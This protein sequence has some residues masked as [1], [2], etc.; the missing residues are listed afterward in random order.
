MDISVMK[1]RKK[2][3]KMTLDELS[4]K[5]GIPKRTIEDIFRGATKNPRIDTM[6]AIEQALG[7]SS[8][9]LSFTEEEQAL[10]VI[11]T[12]KETLSSDEIELLDA[13]RAI[14]DEKGERAAHAIKTIVQTFLDEKNSQSQSN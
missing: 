8:A 2:E 10:G 5:S 6:R 14:K 3:L 12:A 9:Q 7:L 13:Y 1:T 11:P 4:E